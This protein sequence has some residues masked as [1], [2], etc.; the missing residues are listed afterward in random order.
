MEPQNSSIKKVVWVLCIMVVLGVSLFLYTKAHAPIQENY[1]VQKV[2]IEQ[3][4]S[5]GEIPE[6]LYHEYLVHTSN[7]QKELIGISQNHVS[8][9]LDINRIDID[10]I[11]KGM[12]IV[13]PNNFSDI[14]SFA[15]L[16]EVLSSAKSFPKLI[17]I[18]QKVQVFGV[19]EYGNLVRWGPA[20]TGKES[21]PTPSKLYFTNWKGLSVRSSIDDTWVMPWYFNLDNT[22]GV[23]MHQYDLPGFPASH[24]CIRLLKDD[25]VWLYNWAEQWTLSSNGQHIQTYGTPVLI[26]GEY[27]Y[28]EPAPWKNLVN[29]PNSASIDI[30]TLEKSLA[31]YVAEIVEKK[32]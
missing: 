5:Q 17:V 2:D 23:S 1:L 11:K 9:L 24:A 26:F 16:P 12:T 31:L 19:Y 22:H 27:V 14:T 7:V 6:T 3:P 21:T 25:A 28:T 32:K 8:L 4:K 18:S 10:H 30:T 13:V 20:S 15:P 29:N